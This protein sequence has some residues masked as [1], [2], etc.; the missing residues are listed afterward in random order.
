MKIHIAYFTDYGKRLSERVRDVLEEDGAQVRVCG[1]MRESKDFC[2]LPAFTEEAFR[3]GDV[4]LFIGALGI[5]VRAVSPFVKDK[6]SDPAVIVMDDRGQYVIPVLSGHAGGAND[7]ARHLAAAFKARAVITTS[8]DIHGKFAVDVF[9]EKNHLLLTDRTK[10]KEISAAVLRGETVSVYFDKSAGR[11]ESG[12]LPPELQLSGI[13]DA[14]IVVDAHTY[15]GKALHLIPEKTVYFGAGCRKDCP[16]EMLEEQF[17]KFL[18]ETRLDMRAA[19]AFATVDLKKNE[20]GLRE[21]CRVHNLP[22][23]CFSPEELQRIPGNFDV[24]SFVRQTTGTDNVCQRAALLAARRRGY[25]DETVLLT[26]KYKG[27]AVT[28]AAASA[29]RR[30]KF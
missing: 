13:E 29:G 28:F 22:L 11:A 18:S 16:Y 27:S 30:W 10:A 26:G 20:P 2:S 15:E 6:F 3:D 17:H 25:P 14:D 1:L 23:L 21:L 19:G 4:I 24:S 9:A 12:A 5:A 7:L 8:T